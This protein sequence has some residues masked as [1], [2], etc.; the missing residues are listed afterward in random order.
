MEKESLYNWDHFSSQVEQAAES[1][2][3]QELI[4]KEILEKGYAP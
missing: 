1:D 3:R 2:K 4:E